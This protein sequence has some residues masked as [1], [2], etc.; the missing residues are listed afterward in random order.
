[1]ETER[2]RRRADELLFLKNR[3]AAK[4]RE[5]P[6][7]Q[8]TAPSLHYLDKMTLQEIAFIMSI[9]PTEASRHYLLAWA[10]LKDYLSDLPLPKVPKPFTAD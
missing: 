10:K 8:Q 6:P 3:I 7:A 5:L 2:P 1:M 4:I 9:T